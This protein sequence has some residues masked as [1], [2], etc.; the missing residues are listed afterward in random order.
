MKSKEQQKSAIFDL[1]N[2]QNVTCARRKVMEIGMYMVWVDAFSKA[3]SW[4]I[5]ASSELPRVTQTCQELH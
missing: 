4:P 5:D 3:K 1:F 2:N